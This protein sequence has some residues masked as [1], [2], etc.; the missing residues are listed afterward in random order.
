[1]HKI[2]SQ[3]TASQVPIVRSIAVTNCG[4]SREF[5]VVR[6]KYYITCG[7]ANRT[8]LEDGIK[9]GWIYNDT[10]EHPIQTVINATCSAVHHTHVCV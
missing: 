9:N 7:N 5:V 4:W 10:K 3:A 8:F 6:L 2:P 1:M